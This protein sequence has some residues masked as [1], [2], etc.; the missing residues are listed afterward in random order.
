MMLCNF[1]QPAVHEYVLL[2]DEHAWAAKEKSLA[3]NRR[4]IKQMEGIDSIFLNVNT[5]EK[6]P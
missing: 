1:F 5:K 4:T 3:L 2:D 6:S